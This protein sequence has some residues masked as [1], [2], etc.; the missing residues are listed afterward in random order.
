[1]LRLHERQ[2]L[3]Y[4]NSVILLA[5]NKSS[6]LFDIKKNLINFRMNYSY[7]VI[8][9][10][11]SYQN[12]YNY[13]YQSFG[14]QD[15]NSDIQD[16]IDRATEHQKNIHENSTNTALA[17]LALFGVFSAFD[18][19]FAVIDRFYSGVP[20]NAYHFL[21]I[22]IIIVMILASILIFICLKRKK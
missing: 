7:K 14:L 19:S 3:F 15:L 2:A 22:N 10:E 11:F 4:Y 17:I 20:L 1:M 12:L 5:K 9:D 13:M 6:K 18:S 16:I 8:S 21:A